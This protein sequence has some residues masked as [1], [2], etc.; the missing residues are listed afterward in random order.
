MLYA[1]THSKAGRIE[2]SGQKIPVRQIFREREDMLTAALFAR[3]QYLSLETLHTLFSMLISNQPDLNFGEL[4]DVEFWPRFESSI[5][6]QVEPDVILNFEWGTLVV[7]VKRPKDGIQS[8]EQWYREL[9]CLPTE[10]V[11]GKVLFW[12]LGGESQH[13]IEMLKQLEL[14]CIEDDHIEF[15]PDLYQSDWECFGKT[16]YQLVSEN[17][18]PAPDTRVLN[19]ML[20]ALK[21][22]RVEY[23]SI[24]L[25]ELTKIRYAPF[26]EW[27]AL[28]QMSYAHQTQDELPFIN[29]Q[30]L[31]NSNLCIKGTL[32]SIRKLGLNTLIHKD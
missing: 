14:R 12:A 6:G 15:D 32:Q 11:E 17:E 29:S 20:E 18:L 4:N 1:I 19:D 31:S 22:Y 25:E 16:V 2:V 3:I 24:A 23:R 27:S 28:R 30:K 8:G 13:N 9:E 26:G 10:Y 7:E 5:Q 21:L